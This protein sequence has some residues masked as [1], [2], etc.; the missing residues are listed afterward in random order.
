LS[1]E[2]WIPPPCY[3]P[4][5]ARTSVACTRLLLNSTLPTNTTG[6]YRLTC[7]QLS[8][9]AGQFLTMHLVLRT[10][11]KTRSC[12]SRS[13][14]AVL[15][16]FTVVL[17][18]LACTQPLLG[19]ARSTAYLR[20]RVSH[21]WASIRR[22]KS[23]GIPKYR[24]FHIQAVREASQ[25]D[26]SSSTSQEQLR[27]PLIVVEALETLTKRFCQVATLS[28]AFERVVAMLRPPG[29]I[30][31]NLGTIECFRIV[32]EMEKRS[33]GGR[34]PPTVLPDA[35]PSR[36]VKGGHEL[37]HSR[38]SPSI[39]ALLRQRWECSPALTVTAQNSNRVLTL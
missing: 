29:S 9:W 27:R 13:C 23:R 11:C 39:R 24:H 35:E 33:A 26:V 6:F 1:P 30:Q 34:P 32:Q 8:P 2:P 20:C 28:K 19:R 4:R 25:T 38:A 21:L 17:V 22:R 12:H 15:P 14:R 5:C 36:V 7:S 10:C 37:R 18:V 31:D 16:V 3:P